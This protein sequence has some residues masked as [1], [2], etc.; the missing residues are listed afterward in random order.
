MFN[1]YFKV[2]QQ[3]FSFNFITNANLERKEYMFLNTFARKKECWDFRSFVYI[4]DI[5]C[6]VFI[7]YLQYI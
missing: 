6:D 4:L 1:I 2:F 7:L 5:R 3:C